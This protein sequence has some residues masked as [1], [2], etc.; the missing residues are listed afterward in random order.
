MSLFEIVVIVG[1]ILIWFTLIAINTKNKDSNQHIFV[2]ARH[3]KERS[4]ARNNE[5]QMIYEMLDS[6]D[7]KI[8][9]ATGI[10]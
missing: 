3:E 7:R 6:I 8:S 1:M 2:W 9:Q 5:L 4:L 10:K